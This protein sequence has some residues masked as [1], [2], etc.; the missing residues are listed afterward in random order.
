MVL[1]LALYST[2]Q[3]VLLGQQE[4]VSFTKWRIHSVCVTQYSLLPYPCFLLCIG[5]ISSRV[6]IASREGMKRRRYSDSRERSDSFR[7]TAMSALTPS[8][9][10]S[11][12][13][14]EYTLAT[15][16]RRKRILD[17]IV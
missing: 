10:A 9:A 14:I 1:E 2:S 5:Q 17:I 13:D 3:D 15:E 8:S 16:A 7:A 4:Y 6:N 11:A 12:D